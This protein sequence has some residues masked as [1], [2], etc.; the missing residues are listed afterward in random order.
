MMKKNLMMA[1][2]GIA[3]IT[4]AA[5]ELQV[6]KLRVAGPYTTV[7][8]LRIDSVDVKGEKFNEEDFLKKSIS[9]QV[10][11]K[12]EEAAFISQGDTLP[13]VVLQGDS[14]RSSS[15]P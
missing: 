6:N 14:S 13:A 3:S 10:W 5:D 15:A 4:A 9:T 12:G 11:K 7:A 2:M 1:L 8:A